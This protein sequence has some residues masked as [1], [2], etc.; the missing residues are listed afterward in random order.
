MPRDL[1]KVT[2]LVKREAESRSSSPRSPIQGLPHNPPKWPWG[3]LGP[4]GGHY[5]QLQEV[6]HHALLLKTQCHGCPLSVKTLPLPVDHMDIETAL[7]IKSSHGFYC[8]AGK[9]ILAIIFSSTEAS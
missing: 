5:V 4:I 8:K 9:A 2:Q 3:H 7:P 6:A 1:P